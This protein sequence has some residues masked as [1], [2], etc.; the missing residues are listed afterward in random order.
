MYMGIL[1]RSKTSA[2]M[3]FSS[4]AISERYCR[5]V[6]VNCRCLIRDSTLLARMSAATRNT[7]LQAQAVEPVVREYSFSQ[8]IF[9]SLNFIL[10]E[11]RENKN[12]NSFIFNKFSQITYLGSFQIFNFFIAHFLDW[13]NFG[14]YLLYQRTVFIE[15]SLAVRTRST[16]AHDFLRTQFEVGYRI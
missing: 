3:V 9:E 13:A 6:G 10:M 2:K 4:F 11:K 1:L 16:S 14:V 12:V 8:L 7:P 5:V 15:I